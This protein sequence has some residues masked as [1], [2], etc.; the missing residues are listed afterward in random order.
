MLNKKQHQPTKQQTIKTE[1]RIELSYDETEEHVEEKRTQLHPGK[2]IS[3]PALDT[4]YH[5]SV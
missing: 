1:L 4:L 5:R 2:Y 3:L